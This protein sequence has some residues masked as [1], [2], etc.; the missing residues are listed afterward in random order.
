MLPTLKY[1]ARVMQE[2]RPMIMANF[3]CVRSG[4]GPYTLSALLQTLHGK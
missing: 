3:A 2:F 4:S 1:N